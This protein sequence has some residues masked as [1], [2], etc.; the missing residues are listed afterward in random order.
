MAYD[1]DGVPVA[2]GWRRDGD[3]WLDVPNVARFQLPSAGA[4]VTAIPAES[5][6][7]ETLVDAYYGTAL[8]LVVQA[9]RGLE[10]VH[11]SGV[12]VPA[13]GSVVVFCGRSGAG[14]STVGYGLAARGYGHWADDA[15]T[16]RMDAAGAATIGLPFAVKLREDSSDYFRRPLNGIAVI[17][18]FAWSSA[19]LGAVFL[20]EPIDGS[21]RDEPTIAVERVA[22]AAALR[23]ILAHAFRFHPELPGR[24]QQTMRSYLELVASVP[25]LKA[26]FAHDL[27]RFPDV[28]DEFERSLGEV[29]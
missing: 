11:G 2:Y 8:P 16:F 3:L 27:D 9:A 19:R 7:P 12:L 4:S 14:K 17:E 28:L 24:R 18:G 15:V 13:R 1:S 23:D 5:A 21:D 6:V 25:V 10:V 26:R 22:P 20:L 29:T